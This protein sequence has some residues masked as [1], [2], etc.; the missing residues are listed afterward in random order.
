V[1][2]S[3][4]QRDL[5]QQAEEMHEQLRRLTEECTTLRSELAVSQDQAVAFGACVCFWFSIV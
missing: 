5:A 2:T 4:L 1:Q 3:A